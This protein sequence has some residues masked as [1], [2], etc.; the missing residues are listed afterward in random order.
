VKKSLKLMMDLQN[1]KENNKETTE[2]KTEKS[3]YTKK[4]KESTETQGTAEN[5]LHL[6][7]VLKI[8]RIFFTM[9]T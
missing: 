7:S 4:N 3:L 5:S 1:K 6:S 2:S 9:I 8:A